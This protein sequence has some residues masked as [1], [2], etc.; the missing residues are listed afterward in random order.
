MTETPVTPQPSAPAFC[1]S[2][3]ALT[4]HWP[5]SSEFSVCPA[6]TR[7]ASMGFGRRTP[8]LCGWTWHPLLRWP[9]PIRHH[10]HFPA[11]AESFILEWPNPG[12]GLGPSPWSW[13][14]RVS[15]DTRML[16]PGFQGELSQQHPPRW[17]Q[18]KKPLLEARQA[19]L[20][21]TFL[22]HLVPGRPTLAFVLFLRLG[23]RRS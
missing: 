18:D 10:S 12:V 16:S 2:H 4:H 7:D 11:P 17:S 15:K 23:H 3:P 9:W 13:S 20:S 14:L 19:L 22:L 8:R 6:S 21:A 5:C 1:S